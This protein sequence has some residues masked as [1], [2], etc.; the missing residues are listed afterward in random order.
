MK[1]FFMVLFLFIIVSHLVDAKEKQ[2]KLG[3]NVVYK[4]NVENKEP[5]GDGFILFFDSQK[6]KSSNTLKYNWG[7]ANDKQP[8]AGIR[9]T[10]NSLNSVK[11]IIIYKYKKGSSLYRSYPLQGEF[12]IEY[13]GKKNKV[14]QFHIEGNN[15]SYVVDQSRYDLGNISWDILENTEGWEMLPI[16]ENSTKIKGT[17]HDYDIPSELKKYE[18]HP[19]YK[20]G[21]FTIGNFEIYNNWIDLYQLDNNN[22]YDAQ[23]NFF[24][25]TTIGKDFTIKNGHLDGLRYL[26]GPHYSYIIKGN[27]DNSSLSIY[28]YESDILNQAIEALQQ[29]QDIDKAPYSSLYIGSIYDPELIVTGKLTYNDIK[30][31]TGT[32]YPD[33]NAMTN[34][35]KYIKGESETNIRSYLMGKG[36]DS[37]IIESVISDNLTKGEA[38]EKQISRTK[39]IESRKHSIEEFHKRWNSP[40]VIF[41]GTVKYNKENNKD[42][43]NGLSFINTDLSIFEGTIKLI[44]TADG[45]GEF[46]PDVHPNKQR[47]RNYNGPSFMVSKFEEAFNRKSKGDFKIEGNT[48][49]I[50]NR[51]IGEISVDNKCITYSDLI[52]SKMMLKSK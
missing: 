32:L 48:L 16:T 42:I 29:K 3:S 18:W 46:I 26:P 15:V 36:V 31:N 51:R 52:E 37:D 25:N 45:K 39:E 43:D 27:S 30:Y 5:Q 9:G 7:G 35:V 17:C 38:I 44:L 21:S 47:Y 50:N 34:R 22:V 14:K 4:G 41:E 13:T 28:K 23:N 19:L 24:I 12:R 40:K 1:R 8:T 10:F 11:N 20:F 49:Y 6:K 33:F 2:I